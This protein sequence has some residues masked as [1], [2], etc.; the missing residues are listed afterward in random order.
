MQKLSFSLF[1]GGEATEKGP[2]GRREG[3]PHR[4]ARTRAVDRFLRPLS[5]IGVGGTV[6]RGKTRYIG[7]VGF[8]CVLPCKRDLS[9]KTRYA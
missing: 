7:T 8:L 1:V 9:G 5:Q 4:A 3:D 2:G 6:G